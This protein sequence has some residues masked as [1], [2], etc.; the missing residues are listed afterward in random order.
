MLGAR[1]RQFITLLGG[2]VAVQ[3]GGG[4]LRCDSLLW[5]SGMDRGTTDVKRPVTQHSS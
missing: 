1:R 3:A 5:E 2:G 4:R